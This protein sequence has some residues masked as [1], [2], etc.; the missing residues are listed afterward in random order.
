MKNIKTQILFLLLATLVS[1][2]DSTENISQPDVSTDRK[3]MLTFW[4]EEL[5]LPSYAEFDKDLQAMLITADDFTTNPTE[6]SLS[7]FRTSW[8]EAYISWQNVEMYEVGPA[9]K[10]TL[11]SFF[12]IYPADV[13]GIQNNI[14]SGTA[15]LNLPPAYAQQ[16]FPALD[17]LLNGVAAQEEN[18]LAFYLDSEKGAQRLSYIKVLVSR[19]D[20]LLDQVISEWKGTAKDDFINRTGLDIGS[21][22]ASLVNAYVLYYE[23]HVRS[24]KFGIP[25]GATIASAGTPNP[26]KVEAYYKK[27]ISGKLAK[28]A[29]LAFS[30]FFNG[31]ANGKQGPSLKSY[32][33][34]IGAKDPST[35][36]LLSEYINEQFSLID[37]LVEA[38]SDDYYY[39]IETDND[40]MVK[41]YQEMQKAVRILKVDMTSAMSITITYTDNDGD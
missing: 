12:N 26:D 14:T 34:S 6:A 17:F 21:S 28:T 9:E 15:N 31:K 35:G 7:A 40:A 2:V 24:G 11:R 25:S 38:L 20:T 32:L 1:C 39:Q 37:N 4:V 23:R 18:I 8:T 36:K 10:Y 29:Q 3:E 22:T 30:N 19:M 33:N 16:G 27:D 5:I 13:A 41:V